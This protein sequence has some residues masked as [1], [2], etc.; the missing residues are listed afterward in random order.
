VRQIF[1]LTDGGVS[2]TQNVIKM[3]RNNNKYCR[4]HCIGIGNGVS[5]DLI[6]NGSKAGKGKFV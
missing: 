2:D 3:I 6:E 1:I 5:M 4:V